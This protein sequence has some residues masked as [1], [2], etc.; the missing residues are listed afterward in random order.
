M[1]PETVREEEQPIAGA[2]SSAVER[3]T[4]AATTI[5]ANVKETVHDVTEKVEETASKVTT[6][7]DLQQQ[8]D[9]RL[10]EDRHV[11]GGDRFQRP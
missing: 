5:V 7:F 9:R 10:R 2:N 1:R 11:H 6:A 8:T 4:E 3:V